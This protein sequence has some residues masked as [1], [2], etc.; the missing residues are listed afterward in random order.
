MEQVMSLHDLQT[1]VHVAKDKRNEFGGYNY[2]TAEGILAAIKAALPDGAF[3]VV[4]DTMQEVAGQIFV[5]ATAS[6]TFAD[7]VTHSAQG[8]AMHPLTKKGMDPSQITGAASSYAR[9]YAL[10]GL[11]ALDDGSADPDARK[12]DY[13]PDHTEH[14][15]R[16]AACDTLA[17]L[18]HVWGE[19]G[20]ELHRVP[21]ILAAKDKRKAELEADAEHD[22]AVKDADL[23]ADTDFL[24][25]G[26]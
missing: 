12:E 6:V 21:E 5:T 9:K 22:Q 17:E 4:S 10:A 19:L 14:V 11:V 20:K 1:R 18:K 8:H 3:I 13:Q 15:N 7:G 24:N 26:K 2:R 23:E 16:L 25:G